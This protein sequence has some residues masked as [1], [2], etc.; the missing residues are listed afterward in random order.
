MAN[1]T[2]TSSATLSISGI[3]PGAGPYS[4]I[5]ETSQFAGAST[6]ADDRLVQPYTI[7]ASTTATALDLGKIATGLALWMEM[8]GPLHVSLTQDL[9][10]GPV[11]NTI[12]VEKFLFLSSGYTA[13]SIANPS[14][15]TAV[16]LSLAAVG[17]R[18]AVGGGPGIF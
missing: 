3:T 15:T 6:N 2:F 7:N 10:A 9:G 17:N 14:A 11:V 18:V 12:K 8:D 5:K 1:L 16:H 13:I 4:T